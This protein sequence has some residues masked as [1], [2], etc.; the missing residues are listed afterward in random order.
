MASGL[1]AEKGRECRKC[2]GKSTRGR[3]QW[4]RRGADRQRAIASCTSCAHEACVAAV[5]SAS[6]AEEAEAEVAPVGA[7]SASERC[8][9]AYATA[10]CGKDRC[11]SIII[12]V[13]ARR[14]IFYLCTHLCM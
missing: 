2:C 13:H 4:G 14:S 7:P 6:D 1:A 11:G 8:S 5:E 9:V 10:S 12:S 3:G